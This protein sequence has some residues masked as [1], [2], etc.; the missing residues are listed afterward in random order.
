MRQVRFMFSFTLMNSEIR[1]KIST[2]MYEVVT[3]KLT[4]E[5]IKKSTNTLNEIDY[6]LMMG[7]GW[8][9]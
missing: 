9:I 5:V 7:K 2:Y 1:K 8:L 3:E 6:H 4:Y